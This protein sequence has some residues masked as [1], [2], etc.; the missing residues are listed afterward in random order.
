MTVRYMGIF[1]E[2]ESAEFIKRMQPTPLEYTNDELHCTFKYRPQDEE[3]FEDIIGQEVEVYLIGYGCDGKNSG[4][5]IAFD[6]AYD[7]FYINYHE[8]K[9]NEDGIPILKPKHITV[10]LAKNAKPAKTKDLDFIRLANPIPVKGRL[11]YWISEKKQ[12]GFVCYDKV[13]EEQR[14]LK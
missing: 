12:D 4:F 14:T 7:P 13:L 10:S 6:D 3:L 5:E 1:F 2:G 8:D 9:R 11:G